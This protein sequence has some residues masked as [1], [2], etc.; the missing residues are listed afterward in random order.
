MSMLSGV[1]AS[2]RL[3]AIRAVLKNHPSLYQE[4]LLPDGSFDP[5]TDPDKMD[6]PDPGDTLLRISCDFW[7][8]GGD[9]DF[10]RVLNVLGEDDFANVVEAMAIYGKLRERIRQIHAT[11]SQN[12]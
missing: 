3:D 4:V 8:G 10:D 5:A 6:L 12:D 9:T 11:N 1:N 7:N 2:L